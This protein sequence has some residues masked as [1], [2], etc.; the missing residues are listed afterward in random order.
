MAKRLGTKKYL[1]SKMQSGQGGYVKTVGDD[2]TC[3]DCA[4]KHGKF[5][6]QTPPFHPNCRCSLG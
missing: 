3:P 4:S 1:A 6:S 2:R 5:S